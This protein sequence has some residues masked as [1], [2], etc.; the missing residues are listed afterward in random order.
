MELIDLRTRIK[1]DS[2]ELE[3]RISVLTQNLRDERIVKPSQFKISDIDSQGNNN[4]VFV[5]SDEEVEKVEAC[6][7]RILWGTTKY[8]E[9]EKAGYDAIFRRVIPSQLELVHQSKIV[10]IDRINFANIFI[11]NRV[12]GDPEFEIFGRLKRVRGNPTYLKE[13][14]TDE[15]S[16]LGGANEVLAKINGEWVKQL[17]YWQFHISVPELLKT[18]TIFFDPEG[19]YNFREYKKTYVVFGG[20]PIQAMTK[21]EIKVY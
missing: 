19:T 11:R 16:Y 17:A 12:I 21:A 2:E 14:G 20:I 1:F 13:E 7:A 8:A 18:R 10:S 5:H 15:R 3:S 9:G 4:G 6:N